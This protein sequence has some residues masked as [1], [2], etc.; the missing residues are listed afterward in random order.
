MRWFPFFILAYL[1][2][3]LQAGLARA[4]EWN[5]ASPDF[6][7]IAV[8]FLSLSAPRDAALLACFILGLLHDFTSHG[9]LGLL[10]FSYGLASVFVTAIQQAVNRNHI[11]VHF[12]LTVF[13]GFIGAIV[14]TLH[15][16]LRPPA[17]GVHLPV[18][19]LFYSAIYSAI[20]AML[21]VPLLQKIS[22]VFHFQTSRGRMYD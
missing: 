2:L 21:I 9:T 13:V 1:A 18:L 7:L 10:G 15:G 14:L 12:F 17:P 20:L 16:W 4:I 3:G 22:G 19:P 11:A 6:V 8:V 5:S